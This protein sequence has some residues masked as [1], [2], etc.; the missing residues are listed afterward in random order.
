VFFGGDTIFFKP[1]E[2]A[3]ATTSIMWM[4]MH[5]IKVATR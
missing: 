4:K 5:G 2:A 3:K 1:E